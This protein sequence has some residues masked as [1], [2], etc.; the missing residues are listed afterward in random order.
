ALRAVG[1]VSSPALSWASPIGWAQ[2]THV[3]AGDRWWA[4]LPAVA[5][6]PLL[7]VAGFHLSTRR[8]VGAGLRAPRPGPAD[9]SDLL[10]HP[11]GFAFRLH[12]AG[13]I[14][15]SAA[16]LLLG[17]MYGSVLGESEQMLTQIQSLEEF[18]PEVSGVSVIESFAA[19]IVTV[20]AI[21]ASVYAV[22]AA[23]R[24]RSEET[25]GRAEPVLATRLPRTRWVACHFVVSAAG[26]TGVLLAGGLGLGLA[27]AA[28]TG[29]AGLLP[30]LLGAS[31]A[32]A[33]ALWV[34][35][36][37]VVLLFGVLPRA[38]KLAWVVVAYSYVVVYMGGILQLPG[39]MAN[40]SPFGHVPQVPAEGLSL[41][42]LAGLALVAV[43]LTGAGVA[44]FRRRD[45]QS[46]T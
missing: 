6:F 4:L 21:I 30:R 5:V 24:V 25:A 13:L 35:A 31:L 43:A 3:Y 42:P 11:L 10:A 14:G 12:R 45:L 20:M 26:G 8:D 32:Y 19:M 23:L 15:W 40:L 36:G 18:L 29:D 41:V 16:L 7:L 46:A 17:A 34:T 22:L 1:D 37:V 38:I 33:P 44:A 39:W 9:A 28:S 27:G 2:A